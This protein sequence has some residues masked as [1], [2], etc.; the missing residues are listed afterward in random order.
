MSEPL[1]TRQL[2]TA[3]AY[4]FTQD[5]PSSS[6]S[7]SSPLDYS[8]TYSYSYDAGGPSH[9]FDYG[10][11]RDSLALDD[12]YESERVR[13]DEKKEG[14][15]RRYRAR[16]SSIYSQLPTPRVRQQE[17]DNPF[18]GDEYQL[19]SF[20]PSNPND[21]SSIHTKRSKRYGLSSEDHL[22]LG[23]EEEDEEDDSDLEVI[24]ESIPVSR[25]KSYG[26]RMRFEPLSMEEL[27]WMGVSSLLVVALSV[28][29]IVVAIIG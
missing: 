26:G 22:P 25:E 19:T 2:S 20:Q 1:H 24:E 12:P 28:G 15:G 29:A 11:N 9:S 10:H 17:E 7:R 14:T 16:S 18:E 6:S 3:S 8:N 4:S 27:G 5:L 21:T 23:E 13:A